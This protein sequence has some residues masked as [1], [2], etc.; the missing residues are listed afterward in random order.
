MRLIFVSEHLKFNVDSKNAKKIRQQSTG[1]LD[2]LISIGNRKFNLLIQ[3]YSQFAGNMLSSS[4][5]I[6]DVIKTSF[7]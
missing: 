4:A 7:F 3:E 6:S 5:K 1:F 2:K